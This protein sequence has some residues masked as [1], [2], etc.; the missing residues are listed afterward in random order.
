MPAARSSRAAALAALKVFEEEK[1][2][3]RSQAA[4]RAPKAGPARD[5]GQHK[6]IGD[7]RLV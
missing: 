2:L 4:W 7:V 5:P 3:E 6:V 1:L